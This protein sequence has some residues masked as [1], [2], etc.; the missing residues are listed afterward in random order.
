MDNF[1]SKFQC[2]FRK[3]LSTQQCLLALIEK[4]NSAI[5]KGKSFG[6]LLTDLSEAF[7]CLPHELL[8]VK[9]DS[10]G[11]SLNAL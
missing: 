5:D 1:F 10:Y 7:D 6:A 11:F 2:G 9:L 8:I 3:G 4:W